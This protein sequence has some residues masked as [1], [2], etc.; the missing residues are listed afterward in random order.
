[1]KVILRH[2]STW[3]YLCVHNKGNP[4]PVD[5]QLNL[6]EPFKRVESGANGNKG[7]GLGLTLSR[8]LAEAHGGEIRVESSLDTGTT[9]TV[10]LPLNQKESKILISKI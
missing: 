10:S 9:F 6:F 7:W 3:V 8:G 5:E 1:V 4:I 2:D